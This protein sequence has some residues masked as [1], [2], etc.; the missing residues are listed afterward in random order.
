[1]PALEL[2]LVSGKGVTIHL[3]QETI[4]YTILSLRERDN[5]WTLFSSAFSNVAY[6][7]F[8]SV[9]SLCRR[10]LSPPGVQIAATQTT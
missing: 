7:L 2:W 1:M 8:V 4:R 6:I 3:A 5:I 9:L 10:L